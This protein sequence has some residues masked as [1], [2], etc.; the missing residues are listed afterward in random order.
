LGES[1][2]EQVKSSL[3]WWPFDECLKH[4]RIHVIPPPPPHVCFHWKMRHFPQAKHCHWGWCLYYRILYSNERPFFFFKVQRTIKVIKKKFFLHRTF[5]HITYTVLYLKSFFIARKKCSW[6]IIDL[7]ERNVFFLNIKS[8]YH[9]FLRFN[10]LMWRFL[11]SFSHE[12]VFER[13]IEPL[14]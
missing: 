12:S 10:F 11:S 6:T 1:R 13:H 9:C 4:S 3:H 14:F 2:G 7:E 8:L 5:H